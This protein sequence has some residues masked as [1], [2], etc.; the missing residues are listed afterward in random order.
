MLW[1]FCECVTHTCGPQF[2]IRRLT[3]GDGFSGSD[4]IPLPGHPFGP[5]I[6]PRCPTLLASCNRAHSCPECMSPTR[7][8]KVV[9]RDMD[10]G[11]G[12]GAPTL[13]SAVEY[14]TDC[15]FSY[16]N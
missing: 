14:S 5:D 8:S 13:D 4:R 1:G 16:I 11:A 3:V 10:P 6:S 9:S 15:P 7:K 2:E 12:N